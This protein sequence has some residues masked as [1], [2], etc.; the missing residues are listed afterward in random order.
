MPDPQAAPVLRGAG[1]A[2]VL[3][4]PRIMGILNVTPD[5]FFDGGRHAGVDR[6]LRRVEAM[7]A[8]GA[9]LIDIGG[10]ST[11]PGSAGV[12]AKTELERVLPVV[13][14]VRK[15]FAVPLSIDT[16]KAVV[17]AACLDAGA[18]FVNDIS[19]LNFE[20]ELVRPVV[21]HGAGLFVMHT[22]AR[23]EVMQ[24]HTGYRDIVAEVLSSLKSSVDRAVQAGV[25]RDRIAVDPG[26]GFGKDLQGNLTLLSRLDELATLGCPVLL[27]TSRKSFIGRLL[28]LDDPAD[29]LHGT[30]A[31]VALG[32]ARGAMLHRVHDVR[33]ARETALVAWAVLRGAEPC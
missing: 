1:C 2:I 21:E 15:R 17:A 16:T 4:R 25:S 28:G 31:T 23:P 12:D 33:A 6:A 3:D 7:V 9:D 19:G 14:A 26:I 10:E 30:L 22:P 20:P 32:V 29:R 11:R 18:H 27:G 8:E 24:Q 13:E 5:S